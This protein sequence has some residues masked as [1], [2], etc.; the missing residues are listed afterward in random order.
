MGWTR[1]QSLWGFKPV[2][3]WVSLAIG[4]LP[5]GTGAQ[6]PAITAS[7]APVPVFE[8]AGSAHD[9]LAGFCKRRPAECAVASRE[10]EIIQRTP[11]FG[12]CSPRRRSG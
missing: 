9:S 10:I 7:T 11:L 6:A 4:L 2:A 3:I 12:G 1:S 8:S 5:G